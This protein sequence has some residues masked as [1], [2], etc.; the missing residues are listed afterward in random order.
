MSSYEDP[1]T[2]TIR[3]LSKNIRVVKED[4]SVASIYV[5]QQWYDRELFKNYDAQITVGLSQSE[6]HKVDLAGRIRQRRGR[7]VVNLW[8]TD[9][10]A[11]SDPGRLMRQKMVEEVNRIVRQN[12]KIPNQTVYDFVGLGYPSGDPHKAFSAVA[13]SELAPT[14]TAWAELST[15]DYQKIWYADA[16]DYSK[17]A[18]VNL[19]FALMLFRLKIPSK[20][21]AFQSMVLSFVGYGTSPDGN[22]CT[23]KVWN[24]HTSQWENASSGSGSSNQ[25]ITITLTSTASNYVDVN[26]Y[27]WLVARTAN[28]GDGSTPAVLNCDYVSCMVTVNGISY[29]DVVSYRDRDK[30]DVKPF[31]FRTEFILKS[32][33]FED[34]GGIF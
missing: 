20:A 11:S 25:T 28:I 8:A 27:V 2:T 17:S 18:S 14:D 15:L 33:S 1:V 26:G 30:V 32:W 9:K 19:Q 16:T 5:S 29:L 7:L 34:I 3:L 13:T 24:P 22:G 6:D 10:P 12:M 31:I 21:S 23:A 4:S